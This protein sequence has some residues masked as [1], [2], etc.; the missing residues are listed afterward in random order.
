MTKIEETLL[1][2]EAREKR[3]ND[4][5]RKEI[6]APVFVIISGPDENR[7]MEFLEPQVREMIATVSNR[8]E[9][10]WAAGD[11][12]TKNEYKL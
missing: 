3:G 12:G 11:M 10:L 7:N 2:E 8:Y 6:G 9:T 4:L 5:F 1:E